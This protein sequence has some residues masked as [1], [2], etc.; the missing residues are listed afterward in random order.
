MGDISP[1]EVEQLEKL[2]MLL[3]YDAMD[4]QAFFWGQ[5]PQP[6]PQLSNHVI[7]GYNRE[8]DF[9]NRPENIDL[10]NQ[11]AA[12]YGSKKF[13][14]SMKD[15]S[16]DEL[17]EATDYAKYQILPNM[18]KLAQAVSPIGRAG[19][20]AAVANKS[21]NL[22]TV[23]KN[24]P[25]ED[26]D[27]VLR[28]LRQMKKTAQFS[29]KEAMYI[30]SSPYMYGGH[31]TTQVSR[32]DATDQQLRNRNIELDAKKNM[33]AGTGALAGGALG[34]GIGHRFGGARG[35]AIGTGI[36]AVAGG[37]MKYL[38]NRF[39]KQQN[40]N[41]LN[42]R[43]AAAAAQQPMQPKVASA[44]K[45]RLEK[46]AMGQLGTL[47]QM[48][49]LMGGAALAPVV[50]QLASAGIN[51]L[52]QKSQAQ[53]QQDLKRVLEV[54]PEI[55]RPEDPRVQMAY[56]SLVKLNPTYAEDPLIAGPLLK[57]IVESRMDPTNPMSNPIV[58]PGIAKNLSE[59]RKSIRDGDPRDTFGGAMGQSL[60]QGVQMAT[61]GGLAAPGS[62]QGQPAPG[63]FFR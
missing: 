2:A 40:T 33:A 34:A 10:M 19:A 1:E 21:N 22:Q 39:S 36:G 29:E 54:H 43:A 30:G 17:L 41:T 15:M 59:A 50:G 31:F 13:N 4:K 32:G 8:V 12:T 14:K 20:N 45:H 3:E 48:G 28:A 5:K 46:I 52:M 37:A 24:V 63:G 49:I 61:L 38:G 25:T 18:H 56:N 62:P 44:T 16:D 7:D 60:S 11:H 6:Q 27:D 58:D 55:G 23:M 57:Q 26:R 9:L 51:R 53:I 42:A 47:G 35:A